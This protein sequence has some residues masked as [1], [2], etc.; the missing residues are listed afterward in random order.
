MDELF[1]DMWQAYIDFTAK[2]TKLIDELKERI[3][4]NDTSGKN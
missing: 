1:N 4:S 2:A 3:E